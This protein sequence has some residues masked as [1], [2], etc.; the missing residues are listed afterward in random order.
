MKNA[1]EASGWPQFVR[2]EGE[3]DP[4]NVRVKKDIAAEYG[5]EALRKS[6]ITTCNALNKIT[7]SIEDKQTSLIPELS[8]DEAM[9]MSEAKKD[10]LRSVGC[11][12]IRGAVPKETADGWFDDLQGYVNDNKDTIT[13][14]LAHISLYHGHTAPPIRY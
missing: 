12:V 4:E 10:E 14:K 9:D 8:Y 5:E 1:S 6:W 2:E 11:F 13:G 7:R 3:L